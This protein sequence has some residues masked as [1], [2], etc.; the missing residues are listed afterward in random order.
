MMIMFQIK[1]YKQPDWIDLV[2]DLAADSKFY[3]KL[4]KKK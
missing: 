1:T 4:Y 3:S 2:K